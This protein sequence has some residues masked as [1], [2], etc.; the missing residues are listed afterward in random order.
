LRRRAMITDLPPHPTTTATTAGYHVS[1]SS[2]I[3]WAAILA[4]AVFALALSILL[5]SFGAGLGLSLTSPYRGEGL[6]AVWATIAV[7]IWFAWVMVTAFGAGGYLCGRMRRRAGDALPDEVGVRDGVHGLMVWAT[8][9]VAAMVLAATGGVTALS[10]G[11]SAADTAVEAGAGTM[12]ADYYAHLMLRSEAPAAPGAAQGATPGAA[13]GQPSA[14]GVNPAA[15]Q[16]IAGVLTRAMADGELSQRDRAYL[17][18]VVAGNSSLNAAQA[19]T[20]VDEVNGEMTQAREAAAETVDR[21]RIASVI[22]GF[23]AA[24]TLLLG[25][26]AAFAAAGAGGRHRDEGLGFNAFVLRR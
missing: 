3:D 25:A 19:R 17:A 8:G 2:Y 16:D 26:V 22:F 12:P 11:A 15:Q 18:Q 20:R 14:R 6:S 10:I 13:A 5:M 23:I 7:G 4:G 9:A 24:A 21:A 1:D